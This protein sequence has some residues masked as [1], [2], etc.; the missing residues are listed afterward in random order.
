MFVY[1]NRDLTP[2]AVALVTL[3]EGARVSGTI[4]L[5]ATARSCRFAVRVT[6]RVPQRFRHVRRLTVRVRFRGNRV[7]LPRQARPRAVRVRY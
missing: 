1:R 6:F 2:P 3:G 5:G 4:T 7:L